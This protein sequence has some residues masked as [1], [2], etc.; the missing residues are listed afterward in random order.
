MAAALGAPKRSHVHS[1]PQTAV[2]AEACN[3]EGGTSTRTS[4]ERESSESLRER[5]ARELGGV[6]NHGAT[7]VHVCLDCND[8]VEQATA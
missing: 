6:L 7:P 3:L 4:A 5:T 2:K 8:P 1:D